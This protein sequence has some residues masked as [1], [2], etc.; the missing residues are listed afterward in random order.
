MSQDNQREL[1]QDEINALMDQTA[2]GDLAD[3]PEF[4]NLPDGVH[5]C[6][7]TFGA[8]SMGGNLA[9]T[10]DLEVIETLEL[11]DPSKDVPAAAGD[12]VTIIYGSGNEFGQGGYKAIM[13]SIMEQNGVDITSEEY[14]KA[15]ISSL[16][17]ELQNIEANFVTKQI[18]SKKNKDA[19]GNPR[20]Y[21]NLVDVTF[22]DYTASAAAPEA[23]EAEV[24]PTQ[25]APAA[26]PKLGGLKIG[27]K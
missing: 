26:P 13:N 24:A 2:I 12:K 20:K 14:L 8:K 1:T 9:W 21:T 18:E 6:K 27:S 19:S 17:A 7:A 11:S 16:I 4:I 10:I 23:V 15:P 3:M 22:G 5:R 25:E